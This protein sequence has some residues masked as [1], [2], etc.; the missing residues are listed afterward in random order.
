MIRQFVDRQLPVWARPSNPVLRYMLLRESRRRGPSLRWLNRVMGIGLVLWLVWSS[1]ESY[2]NHLDL[3]VSD[4]GESMVFT[5]LYFPALL[6][7][8]FVVI[9]ALLLTSNMV[10]NERRRGTWEAVQITSHGA[11]IAMRSRWAAVFYQMRLPLAALAAVRIVFAGQMLI[12]LGQYQGYHLDFYLS[13]I[14]PEIS[15][16]VGILLLASLMT[17]ALLQPLVLVGLNASVGL[18]MSTVTRGRAFT[19]IAQALIVLVELF[20]FAGALSSGWLVLDGNTGGAVRVAGMTMT[21]RWNSL[22]MMGSAGDLS[23]RFLNL[24]TYLNVWTN[25]ENGVLLGAGLLAVVLLQAVLTYGLLWWAARRAA[26]PA[27]A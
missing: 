23:L 8:V 11:E 5:I 2:Q 15:L 12:D 19:V 14:Q 6:L 22:L 3:G 1:Y 21:E 16:E 18:L 4:Q 17:A 9:A 25:V 26:L 13:G 24:S 7:Q 27:K 10:S 20:I